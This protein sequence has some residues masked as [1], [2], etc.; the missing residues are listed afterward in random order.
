[1]NVFA[2]QEEAVPTGNTLSGVLTITKNLL[3]AASYCHRESMKYSSRLLANQVLSCH[4]MYLVQL[5][6]AD[7]FNEVLHS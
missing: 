3:H 6:F 4:D 5:P 7:L 2:A 1:M